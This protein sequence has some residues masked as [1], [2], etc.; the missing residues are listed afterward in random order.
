MTPPTLDATELTQ[1][2]LPAIEVLKRLGYEHVEA[3]VLEA[4]RESIKDVV[5]VVWGRSDIFS[6][7]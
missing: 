5:L 6:V 3:E 7:V 4:E 1:S 2:E